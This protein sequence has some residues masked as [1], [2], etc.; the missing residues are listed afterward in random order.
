MFLLFLNPVPC[1]G[2]FLNSEMCVDVSIS[3]KHQI[4]VGSAPP[5]LGGS[6]FKS[7]TQRLVLLTGFSWF[8]PVPLVKWQGSTLK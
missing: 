7:C 3:T 4:Q 5:Y 6:R 2:T 1:K 8:S